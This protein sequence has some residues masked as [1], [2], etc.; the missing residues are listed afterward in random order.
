MTGLSKEEC[1]YCLE[2]HPDKCGALLMAT[3]VAFFGGAPLHAV[4]TQCKGFVLLESR[5]PI[6]KLCFAAW[7]ST[8]QACHWPVTRIKTECLD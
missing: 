2:K 7:E 3:A 8:M 1:L 4:P 5:P 6:F